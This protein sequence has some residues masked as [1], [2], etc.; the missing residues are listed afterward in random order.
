ML[1]IKKAAS[2]GDFRPKYV[3]TY[4][5]TK[6]CCCCW[7][8]RFSWQFSGCLLRL[9]P[10]LRVKSTYLRINSEAYCSSW[11]FRNMFNVAEINILK[12]FKCFISLVTTALRA[13]TRVII[14]QLNLTCQ[15]LHSPIRAF[16]FTVNPWIESPAFIGAFKSV[17]SIGLVSLSSL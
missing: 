4:W 15:S 2:N 5:S 12:L 13:H 9:T 16:T 6:W 8:L 3:S 11:I 10:R 7:S 17:T 14:G 1:I